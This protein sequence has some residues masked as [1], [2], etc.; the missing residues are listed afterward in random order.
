M[1]AYDS[2]VILGYRPIHPDTWKFPNHVYNSLDRA[3]EL[4]EQGCTRS[5]TLC[6]KWTINFDVL[7]IQQPFRECDAM[8]DYL[9]QRGVPAKTLYREGDSQD[10]I[11]NFYY[12]KRQVCIPRR[13]RRLHFIAAEARL[14]RIAFLATRILGAG[15][16]VSFEG[17][18]YDPVQVSPNESRTLCKQATFLE[19]MLPGDDSWLDG[20]FYDD[21][22]YQAV[23]ARV[24]E[25]AHL[26]P[27]IHL[28][29][30]Q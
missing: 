12:L 11:S 23:Q 16:T 9:L 14:P 7:H 24:R 19:P 13:L 28:A 29:E 18:A 21:P 20:R 6:G 27:F 8:A 5:I 22:F 25:R 10:S 15:Y 17:V 30:P 3:A 26:E 2:V 4:S 1:T